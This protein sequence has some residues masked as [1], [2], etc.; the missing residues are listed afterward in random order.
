MLQIFREERQ[1]IY[2]RRD[3]EHNQKSSAML[4]SKHVTG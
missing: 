2:L 3:L 1:S 4:D